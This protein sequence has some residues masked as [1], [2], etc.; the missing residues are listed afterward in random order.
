MYKASKSP[1]AELSF[2]STGL[3]QLDRICGGGIPLKRVTI[4]SGPPSQGKSTIA[5]MAL[6]HAQKEGFKTVV[7]DTEYS[8]DL[9]YYERCG[10]DL[11]ELDLEQPEYAEAG[12]DALEDYFRKNKRVIGLI[13]SV[14]G[15][16][17]RQEQEKTSSERTIGAQA[18]LVARF[19]RKIVPILAMND[20]ALICVTH[21]F[22]NIL[23]GKIEASGGMKLS[24]HASLHF[25]LK[26]KF[27]VVLKQGEKHVGKV[28][29]AEIKKTKVGNTEKQEADLQFIYDS[30]F[31][32][33]SDIMET[34]KE[35]LFEKRG[36]F[37]FW[38]DEKIARGE[39]GLRE[40]F[41]DPAFAAKIKQALT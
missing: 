37:Y 16:L 14:G 40:A 21:E 7:L 9:A 31:N 13:D 34:A 5:L 3:P 39:A 26:P 4:I 24:Y 8:A 32:V 27:G 41:K 10:V 12:L 20:S 2:V 1:F 28:V 23:S 11:D 22:T 18:S 29:V 25:R 15:L 17:P 36:Q 35:R 33:D 19:I 38:G 6:A 30:G